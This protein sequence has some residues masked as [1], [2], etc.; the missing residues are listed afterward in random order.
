M[1]KIVI[2]ISG[3]GS[4][5]EAIARNVKSGILKDIC[6]IKAVFSNKEEAAGLQKAAEMGLKIHCIPSRGKKQKTYNA[7]L[8]DWLRSINPDMIVLAGYM[9]VLPFEIVRA[10]PRKIINIHPAD[11]TKHQGLH[12]YEWAWINK[13]P[14]TKITVHFVDEGLDT[15]KIIAQKYVDLRHCRSLEEVEER[16]LQAEHEFYSE[17][18]KMILTAKCGKAKKKKMK[19]FGILEN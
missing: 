19:R 1:K 11:T 18:L 5:M 8:L 16:G 13:L 6:E 15:G 9:K 14:K 7:L 2:M 4:N 3:R 12:G 17:C 10:F